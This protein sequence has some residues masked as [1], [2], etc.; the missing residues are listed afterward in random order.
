MESINLLEIK[1]VGPIYY[2]RIIKTMKEEGLSFE[3]LYLLQV[4]EIKRRFNLPINVAKSIVE[5]FATKTQ[6]SIK[7]KP[8][9]ASSKL[10]SVTEPITSEYF[11]S[12]NIDD[13]KYPQKL[14]NRLGNK[15]PKTLYIWG[16]LDLFNKPGVG[17]CG[18]RDVSQ[19]GVEVTEDVSEQIAN[20]GW[21]TISGHARGV[22]IA[23][24]RT[25][26]ENNSGTIIV[27]PQGINGF[28]LRME[29]RK[30]AKFDNLLIISE[31][32]PDASWNVGYAMQRNSTIIG[33]SDAMVLVESREEGGTF[34][35]GKTALSLRHPLFVVKFQ[36]TRKNNSGNDYF[37]RSGAYQL[38]KSQITNRANI[39][40]LIDKVKEMQDI[41]NSNKQN[42]PL[43]IAMPFKD[44]L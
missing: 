30:Y 20:L 8:E 22:D 7:T 14:K 12:I 37:L 41:Y 15:A 9:K 23:A 11:I 3:Q 25:A 29:L 35:A 18:S 34:N 2:Q 40:S 5:T 16:N 32:S 44:I 28:K 10:P 43:Q 4:E 27:L 6:S 1:G 38:M 13:D 31:F 17:F 19:K 21:V 39:G 42:I 33:L 36:D 26:L 24:H